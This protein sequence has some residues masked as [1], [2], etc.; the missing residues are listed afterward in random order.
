MPKWRRL[1]VKIIESHEFNEMPDDFTRL[2]WLL[3]PLAMDKEGRSIDNAS[4][5]K[6][7]TMPMRED[8][9]AADVRKALDWFADHGMI[10]RYEVD[11]H[12]YFYIPTW[13]KYQNTA[14][15]AESE[16]PAPP[17][18]A[19]GERRESNSR[20]THELVASNSRVAHESGKQKSSP[21]IDIDIEQEKDLGSASG[22]AKGKAPPKK[23]TEKRKRAKSR[24]DPRTASREIQLYRRITGRLPPKP[25]YDAV[26]AALARAEEEQAVRAYEAW[27]ARGY[28]PANPDWVEWAATGPPARGARERSDSIFA[29]IERRE[30]AGSG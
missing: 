24:A 30:H 6:A 28:N 16:Y 4:L 5:V 20:V 27:K 19:E 8:V 7:R 26:I 3:L 1:H 9:T 14:R 22:G 17:E 15:E 12:G 29:G 18:H 2:V 10:V 25:R 23:S 13:H 21:D 11:G